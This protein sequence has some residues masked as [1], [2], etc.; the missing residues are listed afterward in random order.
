MIL[1]PPS[2]PFRRL[3]LGSFIHRPQCHFSLPLMVGFQANL[4]RARA[5][6]LK[7]RLRWKET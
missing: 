1:I 4:I 7:V 2:V 6:G 5:I 3:L